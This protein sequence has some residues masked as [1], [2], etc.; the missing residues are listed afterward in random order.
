[1][2]LQIEAEALVVNLLDDEIE[3]HFPFLKMAAL[4]FLV[5]RDQVQDLVCERHL[6]QVTKIENYDTHELQ[7]FRQI[8]YRLSGRI[9]EQ[10]L[11]PFFDILESV[12]LVEQNAVFWSP[13]D[14]NLA[15]AGHR[16][17]VVVFALG[18]QQDLH[19]EK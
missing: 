14:H 19:A 7:D 9:N 2:P 8:L 18:L 11:D 10:N 1:M 12:L 5:G 13:I 15:E 17:G 6:I 16:L 3:Q 4:G